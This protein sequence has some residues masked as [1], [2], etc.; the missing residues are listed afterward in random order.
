MLARQWKAN[1]CLGKDT[2]MLHLL[3][4]SVVT[5][6]SPPLSIHGQPGCPVGLLPCLCGALRA[7]L[8]EPQSCPSWAQDPPS[9]FF[10]R[11]RKVC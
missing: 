2:A 1:K 4:T 7:P 6:L 5:K 3:F 11:E 8:H 10:H 9:K